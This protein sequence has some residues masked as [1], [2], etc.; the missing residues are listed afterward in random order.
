MAGES[1]ARQESGRNEWR[2]IEYQ[3]AI[4]KAPP[5]SERTLEMPL[6]QQ[7][8]PSSR[9]EESQWVAVEDRRRRS[10]AFKNLAKEMLRNLDNSD[11]VKV[12]IT[13]LQERLDI[14]EKI[15][16]SVRQ[17]AQQSM[18]E[19]GQTFFEIFRQGE[20]E[21]CVASWTRWGAQLKNLVELE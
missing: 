3:G 17:V 10:I 6:S 21:L 8:S 1:G 16:I 13:E 12:G 5:C 11:D 4:A 15:R 9:E 7:S 20:E 2:D 14:S 18:N 19:N